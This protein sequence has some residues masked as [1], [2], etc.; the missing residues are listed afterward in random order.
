VLRRLSEIG[1]FSKKN[2]FWTDRAFPDAPEVRQRIQ[3]RIKA[4]G[5]DDSEAQWATW[6]LKFDRD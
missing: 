1:Y 5:L 3:K 2:R 4:I 6:I